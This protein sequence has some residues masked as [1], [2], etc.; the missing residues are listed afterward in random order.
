MDILEFVEGANRA[1]H[2][3]TL[4]DLFKQALHRL[5]YDRVLF[6]LMTD[7]LALGLEAGHGIMQNYPDDWMKHYIKEGYEN[8]D[9]VRCFVFSRTGPFLWDDLPRLMVLGDRQKACLTGGIE[10]GL[11]N[12]MAVS[13]RGPNNEIA[14]FG[15]ASSDTWK[16]DP[17]TPYIA[18]MLGQHFYHAFQQIILRQK[19]EEEPISVTEQEREILHWLAAGKSVT[20]IATIVDLSDAGVKYHLGK[21]YAKMNTNNRYATVVKALYNGLITL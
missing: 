8:C 16:L 19:G 3:D 9:P 14:G 5:G 12:G 2:P 17:T 7:H 6:S 4:F 18:N 1:D 15:A 11:N 21:I 20:D 13:L 10:S